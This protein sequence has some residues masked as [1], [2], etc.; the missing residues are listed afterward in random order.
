LGDR[1]ALKQVLL[2]ALDNALKHTA[3]AVAVGAQSNGV[4][5]EIWV[6]DAGPG[7]PP[8]H[9]ARL[10][11]C[12]YRGA[13]SLTLPGFGLGLPIA[14]SLIEGMGGTISLV[15]EAGGQPV[16]PAC[17]SGIAARSDPRPA[18]PHPR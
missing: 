5:V 10:F 18:G 14:K 3:G 11:D 16:E 4:Q 12:F 8:E 6:Q 2:I 9:L 7:T 13:D 17:V 15:S 1:D